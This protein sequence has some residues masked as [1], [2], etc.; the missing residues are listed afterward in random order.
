V[1]VSLAEKRDVGR[2]QTDSRG[3]YEFFWMG[4]AATDLGLKKTLYQKAV[5]L[6]PAYVSALA[7]L[8]SVLMVENLSLPEPD[9]GEARETALKAAALDSLNAEVHWILGSIYRRQGK[10]QDAIAELELHLRLDP[11]SQYKDLVEKQLQK[12]KK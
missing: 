8:A 7:N 12:L 3:A 6:D 5:G 2:N 10:T 4:M 1:P 11:S 9:F